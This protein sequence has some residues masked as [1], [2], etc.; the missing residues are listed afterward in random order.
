MAQGGDPGRREAPQRG[1]YHPL[2]RDSQSVP[3]RGGGAEQGHGDC[4]VEVGLGRERD[5][6]LRM[7]EFLIC[8]A[9]VVS[10]VSRSLELSLDEK[11]FQRVPGPE[12]DCREEEDAQPGAEGRG[13]GS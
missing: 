12:A 3:Q 5:F 9:D 13:E 4:G 7:E 11:D 6:G 2:H 10:T 8:F 1:S